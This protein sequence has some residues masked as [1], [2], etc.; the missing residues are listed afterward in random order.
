MPFTRE[1]G[2][3]RIKIGCLDKGRIMDKLNVFVGDGF[4][5]LTFEV[6]VDDAD[7]PMLEDSS[8]SNRN[9]DDNDQGGNSGDASEKNLRVKL[10]GMLLIKKIAILVVKIKLR[11]FRS[12]HP[13]RCPGVRGQR[14]VCPFLLSCKGRLMMPRDTS[15]LSQLAVMEVNCRM[16]VMCLLR[17][18]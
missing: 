9:N 8:R 10:R 1:H 18:W 15:L 4:Y 5:E 12:L 17:C 6:E 3:L 13:R 14:L 2:V 11:L 7:D 16:K